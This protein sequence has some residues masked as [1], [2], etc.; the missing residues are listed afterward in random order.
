MA[1]LYKLAKVSFGGSDVIHGKPVKL[2]KRISV[3]GRIEQKE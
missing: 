3:G 1:K 2:E